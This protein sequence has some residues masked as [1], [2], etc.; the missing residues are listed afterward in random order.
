MSK[1]SRAKIKKPNGA[2][3]FIVYILVYPF[4]KVFFR[5]KVDR[6]GYSPPKGPFVVVSNH[7]SFMDF[8]LAMLAVY[9]R[10]LNAV[11]AQKFFFYRPLDWLLP[12]M[13]CIPKNLFDPDARSVMGALSVVKRGGRLLLFP[14][15]RCSTDGVYAGIHKATG[16]L[17]GR[18]QV[19]V[20][21]CH[22]EGAYICMPFWRKGFRRGCIRVTLANLFSS[23]DTQTL[24]VD[25]INRRIDE[26]LS[27]GDT[28]PPVGPFRVFRAGKLAEGLEN[29]LYW[30]ANCGREFSLETS[31][32]TIRCTGCGIAAVMG[33][34]AKLAPVPGSAVPGSVQEWYKGQAAYTEQ[35]LYDGMEPVKTVVSVRMCLNPGMG[36]EPCGEGE[37]SLDSSG[38]HYDGKLSGEDVRLF[39]PIDTVPAIPFDPND[40]FQIYAKGSF[41][42]FTPIGNP[43]ACV[44]YAMLGESAYWRFASEVQMTR[45]YG[46]SS[47]VS[48]KL[49]F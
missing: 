35:L 2:L 10:R 43:R 12:V 25:E 49:P 7:Q 22:I 26:R 19:P 23:D 15:G 37:L 24:D 47:E 5:L 45:G 18:L 13:G 36:L 16:K 40:N 1:K 17:V 4:L 31:G 44:K 28:A 42:A 34:D 30:C 41:Y 39:F 9:P 48:E 6:S 14:E 29:I 33:R 21:S 11:A 38:W 46:C 27:G 20:V 3:Y 32:D 8:L